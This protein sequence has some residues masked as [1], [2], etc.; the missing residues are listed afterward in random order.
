[1]G[2]MAPET[3]LVAHLVDTG[4]RGWTRICVCLSQAPEHGNP[5]CPGSLVTFG[6]ERVYKWPSPHTVEPRNLAL[7]CW[8]ELE[9]VPYLFMCLTALLRFFIYYIL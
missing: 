6:A 4:S 5:I 3:F 8:V 7:L 9:L 2:R 1:M